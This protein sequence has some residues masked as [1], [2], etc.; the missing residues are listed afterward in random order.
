MLPPLDLW[1]AV[2]VLAAERLTAVR[3][4]PAE[5]MPL[6][7]D[8]QPAVAMVADAMQSVEK[9][10]NSWSMSWHMNGGTNGPTGSGNNK[11][12]GTAAKDP[13]VMV[14]SLLAAE[15]ATAALSGGQGVRPYS[16]GS[17]GSRKAGSGVAHSGSG[18]AASSGPVARSGSAGSRKADS[19]ASHSGRENAASSGSAASSGNG[20]RCNAVSR[21]ADSRKAGSSRTVASS[22]NAGS[23]NADS[24]NAGSS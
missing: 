19:S 16:I 4:T 9:A 6:P 17:A 20:G 7:P 11:S 8:L 3:H 12:P 10:Q 24:G 23:G 2:A 15:V 13:Q 21:S 5:K 14:I 22:S 1:P 18:N